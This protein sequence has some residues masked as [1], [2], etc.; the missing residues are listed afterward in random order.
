[1]VA[2][3]VAPCYNLGMAD[4]ENF[5]APF[6]DGLRERYPKPGRLWAVLHEQFGDSAP[7]RQT[8]RRWYS[9]GTLSPEWASILGSL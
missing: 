9:R 5:S 3:F 7:H 4:R 2:H 1:M 8:V 6:P